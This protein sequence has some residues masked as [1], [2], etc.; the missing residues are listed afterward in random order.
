MPQITERY[1]NLMA[2]RGIHDTRCE[3]CDRALFAALGDEWETQTAPDADGTTTITICRACIDAAEA[4][5]FC[6]DPRSLKEETWFTI[7]ANQYAAI[8]D[9][10]ERL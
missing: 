10:L 7:A 8:D 9:I 4:V 2:E 3:Q 1:R 6:R 5:T